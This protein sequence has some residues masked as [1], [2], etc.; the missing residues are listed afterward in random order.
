MVFDI[1]ANQGNKTFLFNRLGSRVIAVEP[2]NFNYQLLLKRFQSNTKVTVLHSAVSDKI[3]KA[4][5]FQN[6]PGSAFNTLSKKW[7]DSLE[8]QTVNRWHTST[9]FNNV[10]EVQTIT[11]DHLINKYGKPGYIKIDVEGHELACIKGLTEKIS[12]ISFE[13]NLPEFKNETLQIIEY[14]KN[15][16]TDIKF[17]YMVNDENFELPAHISADEFY[18]FIQA[19][20]LKYMDVFSFMDI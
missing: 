16:A 4:D 8:D 2:D 20:N 3:G 13:A 15:I 11:L 17:N 19:T 7:K 14:L 12:V 6:E 1:G 5:F 10:I 18:D 9:M